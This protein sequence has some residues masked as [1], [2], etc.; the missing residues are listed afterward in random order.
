VNHA[1]S[2][3]DVA[4][5]LISVPALSA[6]LANTARYVSMQDDASENTQNWRNLSNSA[7]ARCYVSISLLVGC[8][9]RW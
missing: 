1:V 2:T 7:M 6:T 4:L 8:V 9:A 3:A 5:R